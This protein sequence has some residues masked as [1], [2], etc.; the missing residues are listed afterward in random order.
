MPDLA[1]QLVALVDASARP[2]RPEEITDGTTVPPTDPPRGAHRRRRTALLVATVVVLVVAGSIAV[3][4]VGP[5]GG[6]R[7]RSTNPVAAA[8]P[9]HWHL[10]ASLSGSQFS[11]GTGNPNQITGADCSGDPTCFLSTIYGLGARTATVTGSTYVSHDAGHGWEPS[12]VPANV[13]TTTLVTCVSTDWCAAGGGLADPRTGDPAAKKVIRDPEL[14]TTDD[15]GAHWSMHPVPIPVDVQQLPAYESLPAETTYWPGTVDAVTCS[16]PEVCNVVGHVQS[17]RSSGFASDDIYFLSTTDGGVHWRQ[18]MLPERAEIANDEVLGSSGA[19]S[20]ACPT[21]H[22]C[23]VAVSLGLL[24]EPAVYFWTT[25][26]GGAT[27]TQSTQP[28]AAATTADV[29]CTSAEV[30]WSGPNTTKSVSAPYTV[31]RSTDGGAT[32]AS[33]TLPVAPGAAPGTSGGWSALGC[34]G[35]DTCV[36]GSGAAID[37]TTDAGTTW[38]PMAVPAGVGSIVSLSCAQTGTCVAV[39]TPA[40]GTPFGQNGGSVILTTGSGSPSS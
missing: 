3:V 30:C 21:T 18:T 13:A 10:T 28:G 36:I 33:I 11:L 22:R 31:L 5:G 35:D 6:G 12:V 4:T 8:V 9:G 38:T 2:V 40:S 23:V 17:S 24:G 1:A 7:S 19:A 20:M 14:L 32:W 29:V 25:S 37:E 16:A 15:A 34:T 39:A 26:D 27:W